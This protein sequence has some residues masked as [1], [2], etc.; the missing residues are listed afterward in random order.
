MTYYYPGLVK[1]LIGRRVEIPVHF[2]AWVQGARTGVVTSF[3]TGKNGRSDCYLVRLDH[4]SKHNR[5]HIPRG[6]WEYI[7]LIGA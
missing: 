2:G 7:K 1:S 3:R 4:P 6:D 5:L